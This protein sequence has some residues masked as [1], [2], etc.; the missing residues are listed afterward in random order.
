MHDKEA[1]AKH[2]DEVVATLQ[3]HLEHGLTSRKRASG[4]RNSARTS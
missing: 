3:A 2:V 4:C 1:H